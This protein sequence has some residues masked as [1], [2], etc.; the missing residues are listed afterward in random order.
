MTNFT[1]CKEKTDFEKLLK[2]WLKLAQSCAK[3][4]KGSESLLEFL[5]SSADFCKQ[6]GYFQKKS[7][8]S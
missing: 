5:L 4:L 8:N 7:A 1:N 3:C 2:S 6:A